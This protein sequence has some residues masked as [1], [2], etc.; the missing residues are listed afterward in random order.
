MQAI[1][2][3]A[4]TAHATCA[5]HTLAVRNRDT[6]LDMS[7]KLDDALAVVLHAVQSSGNPKAMPALGA[8]LAYMEELER[9]AVPKKSASDWVVLTEA[10][11]LTVPTC[12]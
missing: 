7:N 3:Y 12:G 9:A 2:L 6:G 8:L 1:H 4:T 10:G 11:T 5:P